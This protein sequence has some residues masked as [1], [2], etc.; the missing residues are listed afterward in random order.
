MRVKQS[1]HRLQV[2]QPRFPSAPPYLH[3]HPR[4]AILFPGPTLCAQLMHRV[5][6]SL[7]KQQAWSWVRTSKGL[8]F[9]PQIT[10]T[11]WQ[12]ISMVLPESQRKFLV[13]SKMLFLSRKKSELKNVMP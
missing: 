8:P 2:N 12:L 7:R 5:Q 13:Q 4:N 11:S 3:T 1:L 9:V 6:G 10:G